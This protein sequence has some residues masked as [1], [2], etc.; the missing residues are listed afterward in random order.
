MACI[1]PPSA[2]LLIIFLSYIFPP[3]ESLL[4]LFCFFGWLAF[5]WLCLLAPDTTLSHCAFSSLKPIR[6]GLAVFIYSRIFIMCVH[7]SQYHLTRE[8][9][10]VW[11]PPNYVFK[12]CFSHDILASWPSG[13]QNQCPTSTRASALPEQLLPGPGHA[14]SVQPFPSPR[15]KHWSIL[16]ACYSK[17]WS[18]WRKPDWS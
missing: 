7:L 17:T 16:Y 4:R 9:R 8:K 10:R 15:Q 5:F 3:F 11:G 2:Y 13:K 14:L 6:F 18:P 1:S 12:L